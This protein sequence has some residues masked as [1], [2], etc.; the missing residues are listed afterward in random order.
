M[1]FWVTFHDRSGGTVQGDAPDRFADATERALK[2]GR[3]RSVKELPYPAD[4]RLD[5]RS[6]CPSFCY[7]PSGCAGK[8]SCPHRYACS[9]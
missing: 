8:T 6:D 2:L 1:F 3:V 7:S 9:E 4:P 5:V